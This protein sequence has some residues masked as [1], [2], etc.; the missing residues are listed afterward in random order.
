[1]DHPNAKPIAALPGIGIAKHGRCWL[2]IDMDGYQQ[3]GPIHNSK[4][5]ALAYGYQRHTE[6]E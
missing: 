2:L 6:W 5:E 1:M 4:A 3:L